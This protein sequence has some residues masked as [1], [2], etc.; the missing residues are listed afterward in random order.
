MRAAVSAAAGL[1]WISAISGVLKPAF[2]SSFFILPDFQPPLTLCCE[3]HIISSGFNDP[4]ALGNGCFS[5]EGIGIGHRLETDGLVAT[6]R[7]APNQDYQ[8]I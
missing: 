2:R 6:E 7:G 8:M 4:Y 3:S 1:K 5:V